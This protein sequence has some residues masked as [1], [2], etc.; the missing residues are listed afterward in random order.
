MNLLLNRTAAGPLY[1]IAFNHLMNKINVGDASARLIKNLTY[2]IRVA[3]LVITIK[4]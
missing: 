2:L 1:P 4:Y 3:S